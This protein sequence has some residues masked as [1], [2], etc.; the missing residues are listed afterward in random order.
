V[1]ELLKK[2]EEMVSPGPSGSD[3]RNNEVPEAWRP[4]LEIDQEGG[5]FVSTPR[6]AASEIPDASDLL[7]EADLDPANWEIR[8]LKKGKWQVYGGEWLESF[9]LTLVPLGTAEKESKADVDKICEQLAKWKPSKPSGM[10]T[11]DLSYLVVASDQ[12][13]GKRVGDSGTA[14][15]VDRALRGTD[16][17]VDRLKDLR[18]IGRKIGTIVLALP[19]DHVEGIV[20]QHGKLQGQAASDLGI[21]EQVRVARRL[22]LAQIKAFSPYCERMVVPVVNGNHD[23]STRQVV[24]DP[25]DGWN[26][27][28]ASSVQD[29]C[30]E[31][32]NLAHV[33]FRF[34]A[35]SHQTLAVNINGVM[36]GMFHGNQAGN[37]STS[38]EKYLDGQSGGQT[39]IGACDLWISGHYHNFRCM[40][41]GSRFWVQAP[42]LDGGSDWYRDKTGKE[43]QPGMLT[44]VIGKDYDP[45]RDL[46]VVRLSR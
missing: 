20:S 9:K 4:R 31:N 44:M 36:L 30:A 26:T 42:T 11:G 14:D 21:T 16:M 15:I 32:P 24:A 37:S 43:A 38:T 23:E 19:G 13:I 3:K 35:K 6:K 10:I 34:P 29:I 33:E 12:Q 45:R 2:L 40:D 18:R 39:A 5:Y 7:K 27:E 17:T 22:L 1:S 8:N 46:S 28:I 25:S 41:F